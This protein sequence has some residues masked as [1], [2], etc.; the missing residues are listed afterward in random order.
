METTS[1]SIVFPAEWCDQDGVMLTWPHP[2]TDWSPILDEAES[3]Y[4]EIAGEICKHEE[5]IITIQ[6][7]VERFFSE[8]ELTKIHF[9]RIPCNDTWARD[10]GPL[11]TLNNGKPVI[12]KFRFNGW[13]NKFNSQLDDMISSHLFSGGAFHP[14]GMH[15]YHT[16]LFLEGG[17]IDTDGEGT[18]LTTSGCLLN[19]GRNGSLSKVEIENKLEV[20]LGAKRILWLDYGHLAGDDTDGH[21]DTLARFCNENTICYVQCKDQND[22][23]FEEL[24]KME[25]QLGTFST[26]N[27]K[28]YRL[29]PLPM[30]DPVFDNDGKRLPATYANFLILNN[31]VLVPVYGLE[32]DKQALEI[33]RQL[34]PDRE[35]TG[36]NC[37]A[38]IKQCGSLHCITMQFPKGF[39]K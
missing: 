38:L 3:T 22:E 13:G 10:F 19:P 35:I 32:T 9:F 28:P 26:A 12:N 8:H 6:D 20:Y 14:D 36:I 2:G 30:A 29:V 1:P 37:S 5:L 21:I 17:S 15:Y 7:S 18:I 16:D 31:A 34:F 23:H 24:K 33:L 11:C 25:D 39:I 27:G 4:I